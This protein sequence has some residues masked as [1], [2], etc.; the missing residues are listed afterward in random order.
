MLEACFPST[1]ICPAYYMTELMA[2][3]PDALGRFKLI[4]GHFEYSVLELFDDPTCITML[5][6]PVERVHSYYRYIRSSRGHSRHAKFC[7][8]SLMDVLE[9]PEEVH[10]VNNHQTLLFGRDLDL[11]RLRAK[12][13]GEQISP[14]TSKGPLRPHTDLELAKAR[15]ADLSLVGLT[16]RFDESILLLV[17]TLSLPLE[18]GYRPANVTPTPNGAAELTD[19]E[20]EKIRNLNTMDLDI[21]AFAETLF[22]ERLRRLRE[23]AAQA[24]KL[25]FEQTD[26]AQIWSYLQ[27][28]LASSS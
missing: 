11:A 17:D 3:A 25:P 6:N 12:V 22:N 27:K 1:L 14:D 5:R 10:P 4:R 18:L 20:L 24:L 13:K 19:P 21:Y 8:M 9:D 15:L 26:T 28:R 23:R 7:E 2:L 16:E